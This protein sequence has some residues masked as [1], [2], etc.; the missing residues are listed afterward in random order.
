MI[1][2]S[3][4]LFLELINDIIYMISLRDSR[5]PSTARV[6]YI[7]RKVEDITGFEPKDLHE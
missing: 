2:G 7:N 5:S 4:S 3:Q 1:E 6:E